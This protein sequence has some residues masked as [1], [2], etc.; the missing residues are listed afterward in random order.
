MF[1]RSTM[2]V[3]FRELTQRF[4]LQ[5][6]LASLVACTVF[7]SPISVCAQEAYTPNR[8]TPEPIASETSATT[9]EL[10]SLIAI[11][12]ENN[13]AIQVALAEV[14]KSRGRQV[15]AG[16]YFN[17]TMG[18]TGNEIGNEGFD[19]Q[20]GIFVSQ[21]FITANKRKLSQNAFGYQVQDLSWQWQV[22][23]YRVSNAVRREYYEF[24]AARDLEQ[25][26]ENIRKRLNGYAEDL[27]LSVDAG[28]I[29]SVNVNLM[30][31]E[32]K[33]FLI[34]QQNSQANSR[35]AVRQLSTLMGNYPLASQQVSGILDRPETN[36]E[37]DDISNWLQQHSPELNA[38]YAQVCR[39]QWA[40]KRAKVQPIPNINAQMSVQYD[41]S[42]K[43]TFT[44]FQ[45]GMPIPVFNRNQG[46][47]R[48]AQGEL[49]R[50]SHD[51]KRLRNSL[52]KRLAT[53][54]QQ[55]ETSLQQVDAIEKQMQQL[56]A[57][58]KTDQE[59]NYKQG[60]GA[61]SDL[62]IVNQ[63]FIIRTTSQTE[64]DYI[65]ALKQLQKSIVDIRG[66]VISG[67]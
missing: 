47:I 32:T 39:A 18:Y 25:T 36:L 5:I 10:E 15:Q 4:V 49:I 62:S 54:F 33:R 29:S 3:P 61:E 20:H 57:D 14:E 65:N 26:Y 66:L 11:A 2:N 27:Q 12:L 22:A 9:Y 43:D 55:Y 28:N 23:R 51:V 17:P 63:I 21:T 44:G 46:N 6:S 16:L 31:L 37:W 13:P 38:A 52:N 8:I 42:T 67:D 58:I 7:A 19:G 48:T 50:A 24:L 59:K 35:A 34:Q 40:L 56:A 45:V 64:I 53:A 60:L 41:D 30:K 1:I